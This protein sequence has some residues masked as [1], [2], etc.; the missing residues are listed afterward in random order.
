MNKNKNGEEQKNANHR[1]AENSTD[2]GHI[3]PPNLFF[4]V[5]SVAL[6]DLCG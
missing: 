1:G 2:I 6:C 5:N 3:R 4:S